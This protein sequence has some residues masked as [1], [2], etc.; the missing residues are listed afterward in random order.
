MHREVPIYPVNATN[1]NLPGSLFI[2]T[3]KIPKRHVSAPIGRPGCIDLRLSLKQ[4]GKAEKNRFQRG[5]QLFW[6]RS[7][8]ELST[9]PG[10]VRPVQNGPFFDF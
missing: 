5:E 10:S 2:H 9:L 8:R 7:G 1:D 6:G 3:W 4:P